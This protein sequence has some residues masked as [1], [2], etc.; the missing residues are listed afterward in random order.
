MAD[1]VV[2]VGVGYSPAKD[3]STLTS[4]LAG[5]V[6][7]YAN[8]V[9]DGNTITFEIFGDVDEGTVGAD[10]SGWTT[11]TSNWLKITSG[12][13][14]GHGGVVGGGARLI[15]TDPFGYVVRHSNGNVIIETWRYTTIPLAIM[16]MGY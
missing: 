8:L 13:G 12:A 6:S 9:G 5:E 1:L 14:E 3:Y 11:G 16:E 2:T 10:V 15:A 7:T 4:A